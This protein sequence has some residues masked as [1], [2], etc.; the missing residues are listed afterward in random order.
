MTIQVELAPE[1][2]QRLAEQAKAHGM[3]LPEYAE[4]VLSL[5]GLEDS[6]LGPGPLTPEK[7]AW[8]LKAMAEG[9]ED[10]PILPEEAFTRASFYQDHD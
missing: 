10:I 3:S 9:G 6:P 1:A 2:E 7:A 4:R 8:F 5:A